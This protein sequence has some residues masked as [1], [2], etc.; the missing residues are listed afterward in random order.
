M[1][2]GAD[3]VARVIELASRVKHGHHD[4]RSAYATLVDTD[5]NATAIV[6]DRHRAIEGNDHEDVVA[7]TRQVLVHGIVHHLP[8]Q[9]VQGRTIVNVPDIHPGTLSDGL[10]ALEN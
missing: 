9:V 5:G 1:Q 6:V 4:F 7:V 2:A 3:F 8:N 10:E